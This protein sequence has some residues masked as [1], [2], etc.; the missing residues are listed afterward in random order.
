MK[1]IL[2]SRDDF[3]KFGV[4]DLSSREIRVFSKAK[5]SYKEA[6]GIFRHT[7]AGVVCFFR[8]SQ[9]LSIVVD[10]Q[11][12]V[13]ANNDKILLQPTG[14]EQKHFSIQRGNNTIFS[15]TYTPP[16]IHP[17]LD[18]FQFFSPIEEEDFDIFLLIHNICNDSER[19]SV[20]FH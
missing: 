14:N 15:L 12:I 2:Q 9:G 1:V 20:A 4:L 10:K 17:P 8:S 7:E 18:V 11:L 3:N 19:R 5:K 6:H 16:E 13:L